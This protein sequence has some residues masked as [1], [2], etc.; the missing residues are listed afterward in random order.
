MVGG[1]VSGIEVLSILLN[2]WYFVG[3]SRLGVDL[4]SEVVWIL[5]IIY[6]VYRSFHG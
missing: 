5:F 3:F 6:L 4:D 2:L 1:I